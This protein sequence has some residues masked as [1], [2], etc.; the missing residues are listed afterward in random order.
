VS[1]LV[2]R[3]RAARETW[4]SAGGFEFLL[5]RPTA[6]ELAQLDGQRGSFFLRQTVVGWRGVRE[7]DIVPGGE[8]IEVPFDPEVCEEWIKDRPEIMGALM[9]ALRASVDAYFARREDSEK[10]S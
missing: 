8:G 2:K 6:W 7:L 5:R 4:V 1:A 3:L 10:K 9:D